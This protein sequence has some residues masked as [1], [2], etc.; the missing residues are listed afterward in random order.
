MVI[1]VS[2][3]PGGPPLAYTPTHLPV[4][5]PQPKPQPPPQVENV[6]SASVFVLR[7]IV[8]LKCEIHYYCHPFNFSLQLV[9]EE[10]EEFCKMFP[11]IDRAVIQVRRSFLLG[12]F[13]LIPLAGRVC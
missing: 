9:G 12:S 5:Q 3:G 11:A 2:G 8:T 7:L 4:T 10:L 1:D 6:T 13:K